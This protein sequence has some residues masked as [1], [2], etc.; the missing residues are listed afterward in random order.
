MKLLIP[1]RNSPPAYSMNVTLDGQTYNLTFF[2][3]T[4]EQRW[5]MD[6]R[7]GGSPILLGVP[8]VL[9]GDLLYQERYLKDEDLLPPGTFLVKDTLEM[10]RDPDFSNFG[11]D[12]VL[13]YQEAE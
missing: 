1:T 6:V 2:L 9:G 3:N 13:L 4:R 7:F 8:V 11:N 12:V 5:Y 10:G